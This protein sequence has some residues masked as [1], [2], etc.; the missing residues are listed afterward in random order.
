M[1]QPHEIKD[2]AVGN[3]VSL[4]TPKDDAHDDYYIVH[5]IGM[6]TG[7]FRLHKPG[8]SNEDT[9]IGI[10]NIA[11]DTLPDGYGTVC[12]YVKQDRSM[13]SGWRYADPNMDAI[14][15]LK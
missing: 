6:R 9:T 3:V 4:H 8:T 10:T 12:A 5:S 2:L 15:E 7:M 14:G 11:D 1:I 13:F